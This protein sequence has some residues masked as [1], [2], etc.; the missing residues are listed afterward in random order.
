MEDNNELYIGIKRLYEN[1]FYHMDKMS[2]HIVEFYYNVYLSVERDIEY[3]LLNEPFLFLKKK[4][5]KW[6]EELEQLKEY[7]TEILLK[8]NEEINDL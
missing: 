1:S 3:H 8:I 4:H 6:V 2:K 7:K 5:D